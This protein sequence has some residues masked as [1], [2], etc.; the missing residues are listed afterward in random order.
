[1]IQLYTTNP[2][3][4]SNCLIK[5]GPLRGPQD[6]HQHVFLKMNFIVQCSMGNEH[7]CIDVLAYLSRL[8]THDPEE[9]FD[10]GVLIPHNAL[11]C[12]I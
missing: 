6:A 3:L 8:I 2:S 5:T 10:E 4:N 9:N 1:M 11:F 12:T 7:T